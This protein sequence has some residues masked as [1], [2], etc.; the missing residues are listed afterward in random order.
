MGRQYLPAGP[1]SAT[2]V[3]GV[4]DRR[5]ENIYS[6]AVLQSTG[7]GPVSMFTVPKGGAI[8]ALQGTVTA[9]ANAWQTKYSDTTTN[10]EKA[11]E[12]GDGI[13]DAAIRGIALHLEPNGVLANATVTAYGAGQLEQADCERKLSFELRVSKK[14]MFKAPYF[15][16]PSVGGALVSNLGA[17]AATTSL[18]TA[19]NGRPGAIRRLITHIMVSR[20][21]TLEGVIA[22]GNSSVLLFRSSA[23][24][25][26]PT[27]LWCILPA[28]VRG[29][30]R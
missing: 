14:P 22:T 23:S 18:S 4:T 5:D 30:A 3:S 1:R 16:L 10:L 21:D 15:A 27:L 25:G 29:D 12:L 2:A 7:G 20:R 17:T 9:T 8:P 19:T 6:A 11:G 13:G 24:D 26:I 28:S